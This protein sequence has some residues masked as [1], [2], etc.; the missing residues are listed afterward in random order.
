MITRSEI[1][2][3]KRAAKEKRSLNALKGATFVRAECICNQDHNCDT[4][5][6]GI[7]AEFQKDG[8]NIWVTL[9]DSEMIDCGRMARVKN[10]MFVEIAT[11]QPEWWGLAG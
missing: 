1:D 6:S 8:K 4:Y 5:L 9:E 7:T 2:E 10:P 11:E 3:F